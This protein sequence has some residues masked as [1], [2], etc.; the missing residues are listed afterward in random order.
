LKP[1]WCLIVDRREQI[2]W[3]F[4]SVTIGTG[5][6]EKQLVLNQKPG[7]LQ[8]GDYS[9]EGM[10]DRVAIER[11]SKE[12]LFGTLSRGRDRFI[13]ELSRM[14][15]MEFAAVIVESD[16]LDCMLNPPE[17][18]KMAPVSVNGMHVAW[19]IRYPMVHW[20]WSP[21]RF[22]AMKM[23]YKILDRFYTENCE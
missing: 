17:R 14:N 11:K 21:S 23:C 22:V 16:W 8:A 20:V 10:E 19:M 15:E 2:P 4:E 6:S 9:I 18:S 3:T 7:T 5:K 1:K 12:D 13:K